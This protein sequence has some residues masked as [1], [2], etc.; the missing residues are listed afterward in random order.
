MIY[1]DLSPLFLS[2]KLF[3]KT[4][5]SNK[6]EH[7]WQKS[8]KFGRIGASLILKF[9]QIEALQNSG[10]SFK[11]SEKLEPSI[12]RDWSTPGKSGH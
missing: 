1:I 6:S 4:K 11:N 5:Q 7:F 10:I 2:G 3:Y 8:P 9:G 12:R